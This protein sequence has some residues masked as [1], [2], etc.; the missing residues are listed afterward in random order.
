MPKITYIEANGEIFTV[1]APAGTTL[2]QAA[3]DNLI[4]GIVAE[5]GGGCSCAT[6]HVYIDQQ[7]LVAPVGDLEREVL[8]V[9]SDTKPTSRLSCQIVVTDAMDGLVVKLPES[10]Y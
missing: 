7:D 6:C 5:C 3:V 2:M 4:E 9:I 8:G 1:D 10:Q